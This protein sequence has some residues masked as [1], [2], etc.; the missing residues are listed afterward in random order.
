MNGRGGEVLNNV[1]S[2]STAANNRYL[3]HFNSLNSLTQWTAGIRLAMFEH[4]TLQ[5]AYT[6]SLIAGKGKLL[7]NIRVIMDRTRVA[8]ADWARVRFGAGT[9]WRRC[10]CVIT[11]PDEKEYQKM[12]KSLKKQTVYNRQ[13]NLLKGHV[14]FYENKKI[15]KKSRPI[16]TISDAY[17]AYAIYP[18]SKPLIDQSTLVKVEGKITIHS[19]PETVTEGFVFIMPEVHPAVSGFEMMLRFLFPVW[20]IFN[21]YGRPNRLIADVLDTRGLMF[22]MP[23]DRR[24]GYLELL[25]VAGLIHSDGTKEW[26][27]RRWRREMKNLTSLRMSAAMERG[28]QTSSRTGSRRA[29]TSQTNLPATRGVR[30]DGE[31]VA[32]SQPS[33]RRTS[34][35]P[36]MQSERPSKRVDSAPPGTLVAPNLGRSRSMSETS[37]YNQHQDHQRSHTAN[38]LYGDSSYPPTPPSHGVYKD[39]TMINVSNNDLYA[40]DSSD[41]ASPEHEHDLSMLADVQAMA[42]PNPPPAPVMAPPSMQHAPGQKPAA[43]PSQTPHLRRQH[44]AMDAATIEQLNSANQS[45]MPDALTV[46]GAAAAAAWKNN[47]DPKQNRPPSSDY[48]HPSSGGYDRPRSQPKTYDYDGTNSYGGGSAAQRNMP[49]DNYNYPQYGQQYTQFQPSP[50]QQ[51]PYPNPTYQQG[52]YQ[53]A[54]PQNARPRSRSSDRQQPSLRVNPRLP[55]IPASPYVDQLSA[56]SPK[57]SYFEP[58]APSVPEQVEPTAEDKSS[59]PPV[60]AHVQPV[61]MAQ[62][63]TFDIPPGPPGPPPTA[64]LPHRPFSQDQPTTYNSAANRIAAAAASVPDSRPEMPHRLSSSSVTRKPVGSGH[65]KQSSQASADGLYGQ[66]YMQPDASALQQPKGQVQQQ[67]VR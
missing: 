5:E 40:S 27:E 38:G 3:F 41:R 46:A 66:Q 60:P 62:P 4:A 7:N 57:P 51:G 32:H 65:S 25:D 58:A 37:G 30:F 45:H 12:Q 48:A 29:T 10:W 26:T 16:A 49:M 64:S 53:Q 31:L 35:N 61:G 33:T 24:Y 20:D 11:P 59:P 50:Y 1:L 42:S 19:K 21:L 47:Y 17:S 36:Q 28:S 6:G 44:S 55:T 14:K 34:P 43:I 56:D 23:K 67:P 39:D 13:G 63:Q 52:Q 22:A 18:Q 2:V 15:T 8:Q 54:Q 9:P